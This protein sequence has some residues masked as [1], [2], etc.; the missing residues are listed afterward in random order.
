[1]TKVCH[2]SD[3]RPVSLSALL[4]SYILLSS[5]RIAHT[6][7]TFRKIDRSSIDRASRD[8]RSQETPHGT[9]LR[10]LH[11][12]TRCASHISSCTVLRSSR[13]ERTCAQTGAHVSRLCTFV[14]FH[15][16]SHV[17]SYFCRL[18]T[19]AVCMCTKGVGSTRPAVWCC[20]VWLWTRGSTTPLDWFGRVWLWNRGSTTPLD[21]LAYHAPTRL[22]H[23]L[24]TLVGVFEG[25]LVEVL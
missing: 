11:Y 14:G 5:A 12:W 6:E 18:C 3:A 17:C 8:L 16:P 15:L 7:R 4:M 21:W 1:M 25:A 9:P 10:G 22:Y 19:C 20:D 24:R 13:R 23:G 2:M